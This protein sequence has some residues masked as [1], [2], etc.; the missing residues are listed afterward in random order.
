MFKKLKKK[1]EEGEE[2]GMDFTPKRLPG[3][4]VRS[5]S[6]DTASLAGIE[7]DVAA[8]TG[9]DA[10]DRSLS[11]EGFEV[12]WYGTENREV[13]VKVK[14]ISCV[15]VCHNVYPSCSIVALPR[16]RTFKIGFSKRR[17]PDIRGRA[18]AQG[19]RA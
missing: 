4:V 12:E 15:L 19:Q 2:G 8:V 17:K 7:S 9:E 16:P 18:F 1:L 14:R 11:R 6:G 3:S 10:E 5:S 13:V